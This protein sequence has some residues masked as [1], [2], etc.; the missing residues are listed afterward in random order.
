MTMLSDKHYHLLLN[1]LFFDT[2]SKAIKVIE[3]CPTHAEFIEQKDTF[4]NEWNLSEKTKAFYQDVI[5]QFDPNRIEK[6][7]WRMYV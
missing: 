7:L 1:H 5:K 4:I 2:P 6:D 3:R